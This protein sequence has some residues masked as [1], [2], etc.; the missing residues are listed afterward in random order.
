MGGGGTNRNHLQ[1]KLLNLIHSIFCVEAVTGKDLEVLQF[2]PEGVGKV[3]N[4]EDA[5]PGSLKLVI[6]ETP[7]VLLPPCDHCL[8]E[9]LLLPVQHSLVSVM[10]EGHCVENQILQFE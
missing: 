7:G 3:T 10:A 1:Q 5:G 4:L 2:L 8:P 6:P 9:A